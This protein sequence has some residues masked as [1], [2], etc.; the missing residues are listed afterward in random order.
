M[1]PGYGK[2]LIADN[3]EFIRMVVRLRLEAAGVPPKN[4]HEAENGREAYALLEQEGIKNILSDYEMDVLDGISL[5]A[6]LLVTEKRRDLRFVLFSGTPMERVLAAMSA[7]GVEV[8]VISKTL[9]RQSWNAAMI[10]P[11]YFPE[12]AEGLR[13]PPP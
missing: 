7:A 6:K 12:L 2:I 3:A 4:I 1:D 11:G 9:I 13:Q 5:A 10:L 8:P